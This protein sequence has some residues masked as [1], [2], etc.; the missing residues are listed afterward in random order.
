MKLMRRASCSACCFASI[1]DFSIAGSCTSRRST[2]STITPRELRC[3]FVLNLL[4]HKFAS[5][6]VER[7]CRMRRCRSANCRAECRLDDFFRVVVADGL[8]DECGFGSIETKQQRSI[9]R[10]DQTFGRGNVRALL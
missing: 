4:L 3:Q 10:E 1:E 9:D 5:V 7:V 6:G 8:V 2:F